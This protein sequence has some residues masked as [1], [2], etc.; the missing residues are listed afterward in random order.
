MS[1]IDFDEYRSRL[2][3]ERGRLTK[4]AQ[5]LEPD[6]PKSLE[7]ESGEIAAGTD[8][9]LGDLASETYERELDE[10]LEE[11]V[12][13]TLTDID[14][15]LAKIE[16]GSY[17]TCEIC[18]KPIGAERLKAIPWARYCIDDQRKQDA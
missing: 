1:D 5:Y 8:N 18:G 16:D 13:Q 10:G 7:D 15:A 12:R 3:D 17:G 4:S 9:H 6:N 14:R 11:G 2:E